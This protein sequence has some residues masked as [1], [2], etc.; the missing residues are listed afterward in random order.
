MLHNKKYSRGMEGKLIRYLQVFSD[1]LWPGRFV[2][3]KV[4]EVF[5]L[6]CLKIGGVV[7]KT[8]AFDFSVGIRYYL[9][10]THDYGNINVT[11]AGRI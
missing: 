3:W 5:D 7:H 4:E 10:M 9:C 8:Q 11:H 6:L 2:I 1:T